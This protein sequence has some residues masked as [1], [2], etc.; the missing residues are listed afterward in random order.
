VT[1][2]GC[3]AT[4]TQ[5]ARQRCVVEP[6]TSAGRR[7]GNFKRKVLSRER[8]AVASDEFTILKITDV[9]EQTLFDRP[10]Q[11]RDGHAKT[12]SSDQVTSEPVRGLEAEI[13]EVAESAT[14]VARAEVATTHVAT[15]EIS[16]T[17]GGG[18]LARR[19]GA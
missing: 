17:V 7:V 10:G 2:Q 15:A 12:I 18:E 11:L 8:R 16:R 9:G 5:R 13:S 3:G 4:K 14:H 1:A 19:I 6:R